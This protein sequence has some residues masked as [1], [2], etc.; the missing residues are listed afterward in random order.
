MLGQPLAL[1]DI[2]FEVPCKLLL[3]NRIC[4]CNFAHRERERGVGG[5]RERDSVSLLVWNVVAVDTR[6]KYKPD[7]NICG[8]TVS[9]C[10]TSTTL[11][12]SLCFLENVI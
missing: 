9:V 1:S 7:V 5:E 12:S 8:V 10:V 2:P 4:C 3:R 11:M 6:N